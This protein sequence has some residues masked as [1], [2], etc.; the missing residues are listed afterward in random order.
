MKIKYIFLFL[1][2]SLCACDDYLDI[3]PQGQIK[4]D[5]LLTTKEGIEDALYG[6]YAKM[7]TSSL[8]GQELSFSTIDVMGG[9]HSCK[10]N[11]TVEALLKYDYNYSAIESIFSGVWTE[12]YS[13]IS[14]VNNILG[15]PLLDNPT[16]YPYT[17]YRGEALGLRAFMHFDLMRLYA[18][19][20]T[21]NPQ[22]DGIPYATEFSLKTPDF[23][24]LAKNYEHVIADLL[25][26][27]RLLAG[28][29]NHRNETY[30]MTS[31]HIHCNLHAVRALLARVYL[32]MGNKTE[33]LNY[34]LKVIEKSPYKLNLKTEIVNDLA[35]VLSLKETIFGIYFAD[36]YTNVYNKLQA[37][38]SYYALN[39]RSDIESIYEKMADGLDYRTAAYFTSVDLGGTPTLRLSKL[40]DIYELQGMASSR[41][42]ERILGINLIRLPEMYLIAAEALLDTDINKATYYFDLMLASRGLQPLANRNPAVE[43]T[44]EIINLERY[45]EFI[46]EGQEFFN[47]KRQHLPLVHFD[48]AT[49]KEVSVAPSKA[50]FVV[51][52]PDS[53]YENR[54]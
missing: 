14:A 10:G 37:T 45:K 21:T 28:E 22:A 36:F 33:A 2:L 40:T 17:V 27:E 31:R 20:I 25:E 48:E 35:G 50:V 6:T 39:P 19:Q 7:R 49:G 47:M 42:Q 9:Y 53:E 44:Q 46:G 34:A 43:L 13:N 15:C 8:Y 11:Q 4:G 12:M 38:T 52:I 16:Q 3:T 30:F 41:P 23:E 29:D 18:E 26:A 51:P 32:T 5:E 1:T 54:F 24:S